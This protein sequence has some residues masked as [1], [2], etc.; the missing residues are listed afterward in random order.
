MKRRTPSPR[1]STGGSPSDCGIMASGSADAT[2]TPE[3]SE[4][5]EECPGKKKSRFQTFK[6]FFAK[7]K[8][9]EA[10]GPVAESEVQLKSGQSIEDVNT[11]E[12]TSIHTD[13]DSD[14][15]SSINVGS[16]A[17][18]QDSVFTSDPPSP[19][20]NEALQS[21]H[22]SIHGKVKSLQM[23]LKQAIRLGSPPAVISVKKSEDG[24]VV[25][26]DDGLPCS[27][28]EYSIGHTILTTSSQRSSG[29]VQRSGSLS[30]E[31]SDSD[32]DQISGASSRPGTPQTSIPVDFS[33]P[34]SSLSCLDSSAA[35]HRIAVKSRAC[36]K[37]K[38]ASREMLQTKRR[39]LR[40]RVL[41]RDTEDKLKATRTSTEEE[42][43][44]DNVSKDEEEINEVQK[45]S[46]ISPSV[47]AQKEEELPASSRSQRSSTTSASAEA[48]EDD[49]CIPDEDH[50]TSSGILESSWENTVT[51]ELQTDDF[52]L[53]GGCEV[54]SEEQG[55]LLEEV[56]SSLKGPLVSGLVL[57]SEA[58]VEQ[59]EVEGTTGEDVGDDLHVD[60][61]I[62][63]R[64][65][66][67]LS[68]FLDDQLPVENTRSESIT[69]LQEVENILQEEEVPEGQGFAEE[70]PFEEDLQLNEGDIEK[71]EY[72]VEEDQD[73]KQDLKEEVAEDGEKMDCVEEEVFMEQEHEGTK[74][75]ENIDDEE[76][77]ESEEASDQEEEMLVEDNR[78]V[79]NELNVEEEENET[80]DQSCPLKDEEQETKLD[81]S[82]PI[83]SFHETNQSVEHSASVSTEVVN[84]PEDLL[85]QECTEQ[86]SFVVMTSLE[87]SF[88]KKTSN[89]PKETEDVPEILQEDTDEQYDLLEECEDQATETL[90]I[91]E[92][93]SEDV[94]YQEDVLP[95]SHQSSTSE[96]E[97]AKESSQEVSCSAT[98]DKP[99]FNKSPSGDQ[100]S[101]SM[102]AELSVS[103]VET[104]S[105]PSSPLQREVCQSD[106]DTTPENPFGVR[107]RKTPVLHRYTSE[108]E[109]PT[110]NTEPVD[111][112]KSPFFEQLSRKPAFP[113]KP[114]Q[115]ADGVVKPKRTSDLAG[116]SSVESSES[117]SWI[118]LARHKQKVF[119]EN[120]LD[121]SPESK[122]PTQDEFS[123]KG[124]LDDPSGPVTKDQ[125][126]PVAS[127]VKVSCSL[128]ISKPALVEKEKRTISHP[129]P[130]PLTQDEPPWLAL[131]KKKAKAWSE[132]PQ[133]VQ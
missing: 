23:Q 119:K 30:L 65:S 10:V 7:K 91:D 112:Q 128:E 34:A 54:V 15:S 33:E 1:S 78:E 100:S 50:V 2:G 95:E 45:D 73:G 86:P 109:S 52:L 39:D 49:E 29:V 88:S 12:P 74:M 56:L 104:R 51:L 69:L 66:T 80:K 25:S 28:P 47:L 117:P 55:S 93:C 96:S 42:E 97:T 85:A 19:E 71:E 13:K 41:L 101:D 75:K 132:M 36:A 99:V 64:D 62:E 8:R 92:E 68:S 58:T 121:E 123:K 108:G 11:P 3:S 35:H 59:M 40:E 103:Q 87:L 31:G 118:S 127:P 27:P 16:K 61:A 76:K 20:T 6:N 38:P 21:S 72:G 44:K 131:A 14:S 102:R 83:E 79:K 53:D 22:D 32:D 124:L 120:S 110:P 98:D 90:Q 43:N 81:T 60:N 126:K 107:L 37:R 125:L 105:L 18:S 129:V 24:G 17:L 26:E 94:F 5:S 70:V 48:F 63:H 116:K 133:I 114:D 57:E 113:K 84:Q 89:H 130:A 111:T 82:I 77:Q 122:F 106:E 4:A 9:K 67:D 115:V 46:P